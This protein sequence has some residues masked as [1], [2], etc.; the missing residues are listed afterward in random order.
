M[1]TGLICTVYC[2]TRDRGSYA[3]DTVPDLRGSDCHLGPDTCTCKTRGYVIQEGARN[4]DL[5]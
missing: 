4:I 2:T 3:S 5:L 1:V